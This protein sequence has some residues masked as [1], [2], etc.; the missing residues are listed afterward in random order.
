MLGV[1]EAMWSGGDCNKQLTLLLK[2]TA[3]TQFQLISVM[4]GYRSSGTRYSDC[5]REAIN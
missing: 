5:S 4:L 1:G 2:G 3:V